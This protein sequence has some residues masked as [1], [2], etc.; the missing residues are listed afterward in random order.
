MFK[1]AL[2]QDTAYASLLKH[3]RK[4]LHR[5]VAESLEQAYPERLDENAGLLAYHYAQCGDDAKLFEYAARAASVAANVF[6]HAE[7]RAFLAQALAA[8]VNL[9]DTPENRGRRVDTMVEYIK[10]A[11]S[12]EPIPRLLERCREA[13]ALV[14]SLVG[15]GEP[16]PENQARFAVI[17][18]TAS[19]MH[20][21]L[22][23][24]PTAL[25]DYQRALREAES[26]GAVELSAFIRGFIGLIKTNQ[27][28]LDQAEEYLKQAWAVLSKAPDR[29]ES[30]ICL[31]TYAL[32]LALQGKPEFLQPQLQ[33]ARA[34]LEAEHNI[35]SLLPILNY[36]ANIAVWRGDLNA[37]LAGMEEHLRRA[38][39]AGDLFYVFSSHIFVA[40]ILSRLGRIQA[41][42]E[43]FERG[44]AIRKQIGG[45]TLFGDWFA[46]MEAEIALNAER[47]QAA[48]ELAE[49][50]VKL[51]QSVNSIFVEAW[52][53]RVWAQSMALSV[54]VKNDDDAN[55]VVKA[56]F[57]E[58][59]RLFEH[60]DARPE[61]A[62]TRVAWGKFLEE[63][64]EAER[65]RELYEQAVAQFEVSG[66][67]RELEETRE[68]LNGVAA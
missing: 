26:I 16:S 64:G 22:N 8:I 62:R 3:D 49:K 38:E 55:E 7:A 33:A 11:W 14:Q 4:E 13:E 54:R 21:L 67:T 36:S 25:E 30:N 42:D 59:L 50:A 10:L 46:A 6:A 17:H 1:H 66:L 41:A 35:F 28:Y 29:W 24:L 47:M 2:V 32:C 56:H 40:L 45:E 63:R 65:A 60:G 31:G 52:A 34:H 44:V 23:E 27:G 43:E 18:Y 20:M 9:P 48:Q 58:S 12:V 5:F 37:A 53:Q 19:S 61:A 39:K 15:S 51:A 57:A 68:L